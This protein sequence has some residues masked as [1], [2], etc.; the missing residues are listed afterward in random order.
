MNTIEA[1][2]ILRE[3][4]EQAATIVANKS[5]SNPAK[6]GML[7]ALTLDVKRAEDALNIHAEAR[8]L[9]G[10]GNS[11][12]LSAPGFKSAATLGRA[13]RLDLSEADLK[14]LHEAAVTK[15]SLRIETKASDPGALLPTQ[16]LPGIVSRQHEPVRLL[17]HIP[18]SPMGGPSIEFISHTST[19]GSAGMVARGAA[20]PEVTLTATQTILTARKIAVHSALPDEI[21]QDFEAFAQ[22]LQVELQ[23]QITDVENAQI[24][25]G[26]GT[27]ENLTG[28]LATSG[29]LTRA[30]A[31]DTTLDAMDQAINDLRVG[32]S[33]CEPTLI[34]LNPSDFSKIRRSKDSQGRYLLNADPSAEEAKNIWGVP[35]LTT[36]TMAAGTGL[37]GNFELGAQAFIRKG[38]ELTVSN[39]S[40]TDFTSNLTRWLAEERLTVGV[41]RP[42]AFVKVTG[43]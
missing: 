36:T 37:V 4:G 35:V 23:R 27:G 43:L 21:L 3:A 2:R 7:D 28:I 5:F 31:S 8:N 41:A 11:S 16:L 40:G 9:I 33:Y 20:K 18:T 19:T 32:P 1:R 22:Y 34:V 6:K 14:S 30:V 13:P 15:Q 25:N 39:Q 29:L 42:S 12:D 10:G 26:D 38:L 17:D 24:L